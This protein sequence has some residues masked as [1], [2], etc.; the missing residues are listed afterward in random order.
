MWK[1]LDILVVIKLYARIDIFKTF[2]R[3]S[4]F[5]YFEYLVKCLEHTLDQKNN[6]A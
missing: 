6:N 4:D 2:Q 3:L 1:L 5:G